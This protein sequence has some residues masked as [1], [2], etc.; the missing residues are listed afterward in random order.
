MIAHG[1]FTPPITAQDHDKLVGLYES[2]HADINTLGMSLAT[3]D[4]VLW[5]LFR[6]KVDVIQAE[7]LQLGELQQTS[8]G[9]KFQKLPQKKVGKE[10][11]STPPTTPVLPTEYFNDGMELWNS[12]DSN[13]QARLFRKML[14]TAKDPQRLFFECEEYCAEITSKDERKAGDD[15]EL[16]A[17]RHVSKDTNVGATQRPTPSKTPDPT[18]TSL[19]LKSMIDKRLHEMR[20]KRAIDKQVLESGEDDGAEGKQKRVKVE[21][22]T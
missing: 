3:N 4:D 2:F 13:A 18:S 22:L 10:P 8:E 11:F 20:L 12:S 21:S 1:C 7:M 6:T 16:P 19:D 17:N 15:A 9:L 5:Q 14:R